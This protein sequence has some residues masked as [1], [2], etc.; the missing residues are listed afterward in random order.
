MGGV[1]KVGVGG[2]DEG[3]GLSCRV[4]FRFDRVQVTKNVTR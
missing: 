2:G 4:G 3:G 1:W